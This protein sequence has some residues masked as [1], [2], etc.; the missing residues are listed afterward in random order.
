MCS[1]VSVCCCALQLRE[2]GCS[3]GSRAGRPSSS[4]NRGAPK[5]SGCAGGPPA[6]SRVLLVSVLCP[7]AQGV[8]CS[9]SGCVGRPPWAQLRE[10]G[11][12]WSQG[13]LGGALPQPLQL[14]EWGCSRSRGV[15]GGPPAQ[16]WD[17]RPRTPGERTLGFEV[18]IRA[19]EGHAE[20]GHPL[21]LRD[22]EGIFNWRFTSHL[23]LP[24]SR[25]RV[26]VL[27]EKVICPGFLVA[28]W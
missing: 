21:P 15:L 22:G 4:G 5:V 11:C 9:R 17:N 7:P 3:P 24:G 27:S 1:W 10:W 13:M 23:G 25:A 8:G 20:D 26:C 6:W 2:L 16:G 14:R 19:G 18:A 12:S 28:Q